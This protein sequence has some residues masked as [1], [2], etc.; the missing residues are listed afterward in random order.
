MESHQGRISSRIDYNCFK[1]VFIVILFTTLFIKSCVSNAQSS[2]AKYHTGLTAS[3]GTRSFSITSDIQELNNLKVLEEGGSVGIVFGTEVLRTRLNLAG[4]YYSAA[5]VS[6]T[7]NVFEMEGLV[8]YYPLKAFRKNSTT[9]LEPYFTVGAAQDF[10]K[11]YGRYASQGDTQPVNNSTI[12]EPLAGKILQTRATV[13]LGVEWRI[14]VDYSFVHLYAEGRYGVP[15]V[16]QPDNTFGN[17]TLTNTTSIN[18]GVS[19]GFLR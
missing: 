9:K 15:V 16:Y 3:F 12:R 7:V 6:Q 4:L 2:N 13:G 8:N 5:K 19:F 18:V 10:V 1:T 17:T 11:F 14:P